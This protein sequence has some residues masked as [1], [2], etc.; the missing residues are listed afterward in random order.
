[1]TPAGPGMAREGLPFDGSRGGL[2]LKARVHSAK[3]QDREGIKVLLDLAPRAACAPLPCVDGRRL[4]SRRQGS[5]LGGEDTTGMDSTDR[6]TPSE[7]CP[8]GSNEE[9]GKR[10]GNT[11]SCYRSGEAL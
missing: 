4:H 3:I 5:G 1:M 8:G 10:V 9:V 6:A 11:G 7:A 2:V